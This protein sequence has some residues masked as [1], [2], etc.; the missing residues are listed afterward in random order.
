MSVYWD[1]TV[2]SWSDGA[3]HIMFHQSKDTHWVPTHPSS[4]RWRWR[5]VHVQQQINHF[6]KVHA[7][8][9]D[10]QRTVLHT[11]TKIYI[12]TWLHW[13][14]DFKQFLK[15]AH[16]MSA[17]TVLKDLGH[18]GEQWMHITRVDQG[19]IWKC[20]YLICCS[21]VANCPLYAGF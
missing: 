12:L 16:C 9:L 3:W 5:W 7:V 2:W 18:R 6:S 13:I 1:C 4:G 15:T 11:E 8:L 10:H 17:L 14:Q 20:F 19:G 21:T